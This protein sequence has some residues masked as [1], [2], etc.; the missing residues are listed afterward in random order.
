MAMENAGTAWRSPDSWE[1][2]GSLVAVEIRDKNVS[3]LA[4]SMFQDHGFVFRA[5]RSQG[6]NSVRLSP[7]VFNTEEEIARFFEIATA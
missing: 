1:L 2:G 7:N 6:L 5:F 3:E 4:G